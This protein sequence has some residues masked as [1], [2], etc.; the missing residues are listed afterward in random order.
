MN[1]ELN[2]NNLKDRGK[3]THRETMLKRVT[4]HTWICLDCRVISCNFDVNPLLHTTNYFLPSCT[5]QNSCLCT[6]QSSTYFLIKSAHASTALP[7][8]C[9]TTQNSLLSTRT[10]GIYIGIWLLLCFALLYLHDTI[11]E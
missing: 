4:A 1:F 6:K 5:A 9:E 11:N 3:R 7:K 8:L 2:M 10:H